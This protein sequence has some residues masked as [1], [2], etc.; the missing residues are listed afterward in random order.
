M[1]DKHAPY[2]H[3]S[4]AEGLR[5]RRTARAALQ[6]LR[7]VV[8]GRCFYERCSSSFTGMSVVFRRSRVNVEESCSSS[9]KG[10]RRSGIGEATRHRDPRL[11]AQLKRALERGGARGAETLRGV[12][13]T[14]SCGDRPLPS[15]AKRG[16]LPRHGH[17]AMVG[18][19]ST[20]GS[21]VMARPRLSHQA[22]ASCQKRKRTAASDAVAPR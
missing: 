16:A 8:R 7:F 14:E 3:E 18:C 20:E 13:S 11:V 15:A 12:P 6:A 9:F 17:T 19:P 21:G 4:G 10:T 22:S 5:P 1:P 2:V